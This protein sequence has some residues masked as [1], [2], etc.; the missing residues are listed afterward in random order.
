MRSSGGGHGRNPFQLQGGFWNANCQDAT[1]PG[2]GID[3][4]QWTG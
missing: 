2:L 3:P 1:N 4:L